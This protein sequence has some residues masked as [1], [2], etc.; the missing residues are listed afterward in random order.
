MAKGLNLLP[1][2]LQPIERE[3]DDRDLRKRIDAILDRCSPQQ[4]ELIHRLAAVL[5]EP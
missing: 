3:E 1:R 2:I 5:V 4:L